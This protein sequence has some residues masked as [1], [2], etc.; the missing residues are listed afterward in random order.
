MLNMNCHLISIIICTIIVFLSL[1][2]SVYQID[3]LSDTQRLSM[4]FP[5]SCIPAGTRRRIDV[6]RRHDKVMCPLGVVKVNGYIF[7]GNNY[8]CQFLCPWSRGYK[9]K[10]SSFGRTHGAPYRGYGYVPLMYG[11]NVVRRMGTQQQLN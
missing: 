4:V 9:T 7:T 6:I 11:G 3:K 10:L 5:K 8:Y 2:Q 1:L